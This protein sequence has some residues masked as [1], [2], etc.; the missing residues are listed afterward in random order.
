MP[1]IHLQVDEPHHD[2]FFWDP[3]LMHSWL[4]KTF[5]R[6]RDQSS[7]KRQIEY[8][9]HSIGIS[10]DARNVATPTGPVILKDQKNAF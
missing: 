6:K 10:V 1:A 7:G 8:W 9:H 5:A 4:T 3:D 2:V